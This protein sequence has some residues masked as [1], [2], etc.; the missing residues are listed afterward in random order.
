MKEVGSGVN[1]GRKKLLALLADPTV[2]VIVIEHKDRLTRF[3]FCYIDQAAFKS[4]N[5][6]NAALYRNKFQI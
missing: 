1:D 2:T 6:Y 4:K 3:G 5:L